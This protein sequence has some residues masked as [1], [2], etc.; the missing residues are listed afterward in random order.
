[1]ER[2]SLTKK[3]TTWH[4]YCG[5]HMFKS[6][7]SP[8][9]FRLLLSNCLNW[10]IYCDDHS[11]LSSNNHSSNMNDFIYTSHN[12]NEC[13]QEKEWILLILRLLFWVLPCSFYTLLPIWTS[14]ILRCT[15]N[16]FTWTTRSF[17][18]KHMHINNRLTF[19]L[20]FV[21]Q[22]ISSQFTHNK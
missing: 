17:Y 14:P 20:I 19:F 7:W 22:L 21:Y 13:N 15:C 3:I 12:N 2:R 6:H 18:H 4:Q 5:S 10:K 8:D 9:F 16:S 11:S 1:M